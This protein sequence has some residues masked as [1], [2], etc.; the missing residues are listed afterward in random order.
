MQAPP[1]AGVAVAYKY[2]E[3]VYRCS[4]L[5]SRYL[6]RNSPDYMGGLLALN[7]DRSYVMFEYLEQALRTGQVPEECF[8]RLPDIH[9]T[10]GGRQDGAAEFFARAM[11]GASKGGCMYVPEI[12]DAMLQ[13]SHYGIHRARLCNDSA[14]ELGRTRLTHVFHSP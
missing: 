3:Q 2:N 8:A 12:A 6:V 11:T 4:A 14:L 7:N 1:Q 10:F 13:L 5:A 9:T